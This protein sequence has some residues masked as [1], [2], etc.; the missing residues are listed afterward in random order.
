[1]EKMSYMNAVAKEY[2]AKQAIKIEQRN[3]GKWAIYKIQVNPDF[4]CKYGRSVDELLT[5]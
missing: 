3:Q 5:N 1:M 2:G 4:F